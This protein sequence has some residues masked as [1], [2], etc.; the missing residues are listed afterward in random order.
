MK[1]FHEMFAAV[2]K[3]TLWEPDYFIFLGKDAMFEKVMDLLNVNQFEFHYSSHI[4]V[5]AGLRSRK[6]FK[7]LRLH[8]PGFISVPVHVHV[9]TSVYMLS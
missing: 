5:Q 3:G 9:P 2:C 4:L 6:V 1:H 7:E 8:S